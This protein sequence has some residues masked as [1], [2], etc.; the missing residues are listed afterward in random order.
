VDTTPPLARP[1]CTSLDPAERPH[2]VHHGARV[3][4]PATL[5]EGGKAGSVVGGVGGV[6]R[7]ASPSSRL[8]EGRRG[9]LS[10]VSQL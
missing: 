6:A 7:F 10:D 9:G 3:G 8:R 2:R 1:W 5:F 4:L